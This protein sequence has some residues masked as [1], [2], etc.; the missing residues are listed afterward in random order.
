MPK[1]LGS[2]FSTKMHESC[3]LIEKERVKETYQCLRTKTLERFVEE[4]NKKCLDW[5]GRRKVVRRV[6]EKF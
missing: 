1:M 6:F 5:I 2:K 4:N 3:D